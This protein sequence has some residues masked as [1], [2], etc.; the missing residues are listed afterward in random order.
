M[1]ASQIT[2]L[3]NPMRLRLGIKRAFTGD[4]S[5][6]LSELFQN[7][8]RAGARNVQIITDDRGFIYQDDGRGLRNEADF[9]AIVKLGESGW[10][11]RVE[12][13]Q[14]PMGLGIH[15][16]LAHEKVEAVSFTSNMLSLKLDANRWWT[17]EQYA[18][19]WRENLNR[20]SFPAPGMNIGITCSKELIEKLVGVLIG[21]PRVTCSP[22]QGYYDLLNITLNDTA[23]NTKIHGAA[24]PMVPLI[25]ADYQN[26]RLV[27]GL[28]DKS[29]YST[30]TG[31]WIN[32][33]GQMIEVPHHSHFNAYLE[34]RRGRPVNPMAP[35]RRGIIKDQALQ[36]LLNF[37][38]DALAGYFTQ[39]AVNEINA[40]ALQGFYRDYP[41]QARNLPVFVAARRKPYE[42][43]NDVGEVARSFDPAV[44]T[45][46]H[47]PLLLAES[48]QVVQEDG[49]VFSDTYGLH[50]FLEMI[51]AAY[52]VLAADQSRLSI[53]HL[54]WKP[55][56]QMSLPEGCSLIF[57]DAGQWGLSTEEKPPIEWRD[58]SNHVVFTFN[59]P[60]NWDVDSVDFTVGGADPQAFYQSDA[61]AAFDPT[62]DDGRSYE[63]MSESYQQSCEREIR[64]IIGNAV[65]QDFSWGDLIGFVPEGEKIVRLTPEYKGRRNH[66]PET[67]SLSLSNGEEVRLRVV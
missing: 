58:V 46:E 27:I 5:E 33:F 65:P 7:S 34:V 16:L 37:I 57:H 11:Q 59:D 13:E 36:D 39:T 4:I 63:E 41:E 42:S 12:E 3:I 25:E 60:S 44:F 26:N 17:N 40:L 38:R 10:D 23:I 54:W 35:S 56:A 67:V 14:Q 49:K 28:H 18:V 9:E 1:S 66:K 43:G 51:G 53:Q 50:T 2:D 30:T 45:Y 31:L 47:P 55:G 19:N 8:Q 48:V 62:N 52:E 22:A 24:L 64:E 29:G 20:I 32:W 61:W 21:N 15:S 6:I